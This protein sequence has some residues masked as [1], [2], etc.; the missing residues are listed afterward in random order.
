VIH[1]Q[2][3]LTVITKDGKVLLGKKKRGYAVGIWNGYGGKVE[4]GET[5]EEAMLR[6]LWEESTVR[7]VKHE[8]VGYI[9]F[10][11]NIEEYISECH[12]YRIDEY[13]GEIEETEEM[14]PQWFD[15][16]KIPYDSMWPDDIHWLPLVLAGKKV[17]GRFLLKD[18]TTIDSYELS[19]VDSL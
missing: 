18:N 11:S 1:K 19:E 14:L 13:S 17:T 8:K 3:T 4:P 2:L 6:E 5:T 10:T 9:E 16:D 7:A 15:I 12:L